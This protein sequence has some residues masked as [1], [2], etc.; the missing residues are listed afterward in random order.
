M[1][2]RNAW[3]IA[4]WS[5]EVDTKPLARRICN[6]PVVLFRDRQHGAV[7]LE[8]RCCHRGAPLHLGRVVDS[9]LQCGYH[10]LVFDSAG[11]CV[12]I[13]AQVLIPERARIRSYP[14]VEK[15]QLIWI[16]TGDPAK[17]NTSKIIDYPFHNDRKNW[18]H[19]HSVLH[20]KANYLLL[21]DNLMDNTHVGYVHR[22]TI[23]GD[24]LAFVKAKEILTRRADGLKLMRW[25]LNVD[26]PPTY[27]K[28]VGFKGKVDRW[29]EFDYVAPGNVALW[30]GALNVGEGAYENGKREGGF[31]LRTLNVLTPE[32]ESSCFYFWSSAIGY[33]QD[34]PEA[35]EQMFKAVEETFLEDKAM[36]EGQQLRLEEFGETSLIGIA[37]DS[38]RIQM[39]RTVEKMLAEESQTPVT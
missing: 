37:N 31:S 28:A 11:Q 27:A 33:N 22:T 9:G 29:A 12:E 10:G 17:A 23:G 32:T 36:V 18:P 38:T 20:I 15:D 30:S 8:D 24:P 6:Q 7:A 13:P 26:P 19:K 21:V 35:I 34:D 2:I 4:A 16:W 14:V 25:L 5:D 3:Y 39:R 1:F